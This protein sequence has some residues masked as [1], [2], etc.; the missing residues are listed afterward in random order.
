MPPKD[1]Y[2]VTTPIYYPNDIPHIGH[3]YYQD[4]SGEVHGLKRPNAS[5]HVY[6]E[7]CER[8]NRRGPTSTL[9]VASCS[10]GP[11]PRDDCNDAVATTF[12]GAPELCNRVDDDCW[13][14]VCR[15]LQFGPQKIGHWPS[16]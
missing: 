1:T 4:E 6:F 14:Q 3:G 7:L 10:G 16:V 12:G 2:Y 11:F 15:A 8:N 13:Q 9:N 5:G